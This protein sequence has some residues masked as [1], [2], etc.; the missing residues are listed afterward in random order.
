MRTLYGE[1]NARLSSRG[2]AARHTCAVRRLP[3]EFRSEQWPQMRQ[4]PADED[5]GQ[6]VNDGKHAELG[7]RGDDADCCEHRQ[8]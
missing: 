5:S 4:M 2:E 7:E 3:Y 8:K 1:D 6:I